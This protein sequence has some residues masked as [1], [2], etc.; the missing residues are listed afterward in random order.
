M[1]TLAVNISLCVCV[2]WRWIIFQEKKKKKYSDKLHFASCEG[3]DCCSNGIFSTQTE[4]QALLLLFLFF[5]VT[6]YEA[7]K[8]IGAI[9]TIIAIFQSHTL[10]RGISRWCALAVF[11]PLCLHLSRIARFFLIICDGNFEDSHFKMEI[12][13]ISYEFQQSMT[14]SHNINL[15]VIFS[16]HSAFFIFHK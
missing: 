6:W 8:R 2:C 7:K 3:W 13:W 14:I 15:F 5:A 4:T 11:S 12:L 1:Y 16:F 9:P 10:Q